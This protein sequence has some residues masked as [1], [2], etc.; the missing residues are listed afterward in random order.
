MSLDDVAGVFRDH[1]SFPNGICRHVDERDAE[2]ERACSVWSIV[3]DLTERRFGIAA[4]PPCEHEY[5]WL[6]L[7]EATAGAGAIAVGD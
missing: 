7:A 2:T 4:H 3:M 5:E 6:S 1:Y